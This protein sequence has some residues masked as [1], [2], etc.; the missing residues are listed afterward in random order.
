MYSS[1]RGEEKKSLK[2]GEQYFLHLCTKHTKK[3][4]F[5]I[6]YIHMLSLEE[7]NDQLLQRLRFDSRTDIKDYIR[8]PRAVKNC[9]CCTLLF[10]HILSQKTFARPLWWLDFENVVTDEKHFLLQPKKNWPDLII[11]NMQQIRWGVQF[12][13]EKHEEPTIVGAPGS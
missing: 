11:L 4:F 2:N 8:V 3:T 1:V 13:L 10:L 7:K 5:Y 12:L 9:T 6:L